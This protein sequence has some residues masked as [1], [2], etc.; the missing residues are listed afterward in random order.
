VHLNVLN[1]KVHFW[2]AFLATIPVLVMIATGL[3]LQ[4]KKHWTWVQPAEQRGASTVPAVDFAQIMTSLQG[5]PSLGVRGWDD[6]DKIDVRPGKGMAKVTLTSYWE[7]QIDLS[8]GRVLQT[9]YRRSDLIESIHDGSFF[10]GNWT[11]LGLFLP[12]GATLLLLWL[13]GLWMVWVQLGGKARMK[14]KRRHRV[15][16]RAAVVAFVLGLPA[17]LA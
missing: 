2:A 12:A 4:S 14:K 16:R 6:V 11:K 13:T 1:R 5:V 7:V 10:G 17:F 15:Y 3:L 9:A 8:D